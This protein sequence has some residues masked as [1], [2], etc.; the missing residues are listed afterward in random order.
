MLWTGGYD[1]T[2]MLIKMLSN[3]RI[4]GGDIVPVYIFDPDRK[5]HEYELKAM[6]KIHSMLKRRPFPNRLGELE[7][8]SKDAIPDDE[9]LSASAKALHEKYGLGRQYDWLARY[10]KDRGVKLYLG[11]EAGPRSIALQC[12][13]G[14]RLGF[15]DST[16]GKIVV[17]ND[18]FNDLFNIFSHFVLPILDDTEISMKDFASANGF[19]D[20]MSQ[21]WFCHDPIDKLP[22]GLCNPCLEKYGSGL[23]C[24][25]PVKSIKRVKVLLGVERIFGVR[26]R[27]RFASVW[28]RFLSLKTLCKVSLPS[29]EIK[30]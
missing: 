26:G 24:L 25:L 23:G 27:K 7:I 19:D 28:R 15:E 5:S 11:V 12:F 3:N 17:A 13:K 6:R 30:K 18:G 4:G 20:V 8:V 22:C 29:M 2:Y 16:S 21:I 9:S 14:E 1:S 10:A